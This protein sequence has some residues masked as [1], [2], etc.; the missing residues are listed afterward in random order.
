MGGSAASST[1]L[2]ISHANHGDVVALPYFPN[3]KIACGHFKAGRTDSEEHRQLPPAYGQLDPSRHFIARASGNSMDG[4]KNP[5]RDGAYLLLELLSP[6]KAGS[7]TGTVMAIERQ[8]ESSGDNQYLLRVVT[9]S[10]DGR[11]VLKANN[12]EY[13]DLDATD[14]MRTLA[15]LRA[16][17]DPLDLV[18]GQAFLR[19]EIPPLFGEAFSQ[20]SWNSGHVTLSDKKA[21]V[22]LVTL[23]KRGKAEEHRYLDHWIDEHRFHWQS[24]NATTPAGKRGLEVIHHQAR[25]IDLHLFVRNEKLAAGKAAPFVYHGKVVYLSHHGAGPM[26]VTFDVPNAAL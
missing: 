19:E 23:S 24:Q 26:S 6:S 9:K 11:Y 25:G 15:R 1:G 4:G 7:I 12:P 17:V 21:H 10:R 3:L 18:I 13:E 5:I 2:P 16:V 20:G 14:D 22:L 8:D